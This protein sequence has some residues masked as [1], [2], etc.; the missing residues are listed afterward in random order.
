[1]PEEFIEPV[2][3][4]IDKKFRVTLPTKWRNKFFHDSRE[5]SIITNQG[6]YLSGDNLLTGLENDILRV[7]SMDEA[8]KQAIKLRV[9]W[10]YPRLKLENLPILSYSMMEEREIDGEGRLYIPHKLFKYAK[11]EK[12]AVVLGAPNK[13]LLMSPETYDS[14]LGLLNI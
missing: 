5:I 3:T 14:Y 1:M 6:A 7:E 4:N 11:L 2:R 10:I 13:M 12:E 9:L 8:L